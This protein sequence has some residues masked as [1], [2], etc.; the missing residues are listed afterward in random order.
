MRSPP[1]PR[2]LLLDEIAGGLTEHEIREL[3]GTIGDI[4]SQGVSI[5]WVEH[6]VHALMSVVDRLVV[7]DFGRKLDEGDPQTVIENPVVREVYL[8]IAVE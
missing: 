8:G 7:I 2:V 5:V 1:R 4:R 6:I 3:V